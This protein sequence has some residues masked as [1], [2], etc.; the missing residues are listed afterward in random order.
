MLVIC[1]DQSNDLPNIF[2]VIS[3]G[4]CIVYG[5][6]CGVKRRRKKTKNK[7]KSKKD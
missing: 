1:Q 3:L 6:F 4:Q 7:T 2:R 5:E